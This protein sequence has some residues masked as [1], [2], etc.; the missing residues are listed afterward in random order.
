MFP[1]IRQQSNTRNGGPAAINMA[2]LIDMVFILLIFF[3]VTTTFVQ[4]TG[5]EVTRPEAAYA[6]ALEAESLRISIAASGAIYAEG[7][8]LDLA[9]LREQ[10]RRFIDTHEGGSVVVI[11]D[12]ALASGR[13]VEVMDDVKRGG[14]E[15][16]AIAT[17][18]REQ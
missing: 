6:Q 7:R 9:A 17:R 16:I 10:V 8:E 15:D 3:L 11:P 2:P 13:L 18:Q 14:A 4:D 5:I 12:E 1:S